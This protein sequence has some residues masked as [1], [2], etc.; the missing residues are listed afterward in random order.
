[1]AYRTIALWFRDEGV[2]IDNLFWWP[3]REVVHLAYISMP[4]AALG[5]RA[6]GLGERL[7]EK[8]TKKRTTDERIP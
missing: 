3:W 1:M 4:P 6:G 7:P 2:L 5:R 8:C